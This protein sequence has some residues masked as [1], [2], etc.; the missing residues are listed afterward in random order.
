VNIRA[1]IESREHSHSLE[2]ATDDRVQSITIQNT[3]RA[4]CLVRLVED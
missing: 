4:G 1:T 2:V 3:L